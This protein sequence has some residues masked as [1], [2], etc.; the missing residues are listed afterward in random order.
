M[1]YLRYY[2]SNS[3]NFYGI[4]GINVFLVLSLVDKT[5]IKLAEFLL[6]NFLKEGK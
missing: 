6:P 2:K 1:N 5:Y 4:A 3:I